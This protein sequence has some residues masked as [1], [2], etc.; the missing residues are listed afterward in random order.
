MFTSPHG[1]TLFYLYCF[2]GTRN[3][4]NSAHAMGPLVI[5]CTVLLNG[6]IA[7]EN[8]LA[9]TPPMGW[10]SWQR[11]RC[12]TNCAQ[13]PDDCISEKLIKRTV[14]RIISDGWKEVG[15]EYVITDDCWPERERDRDTQEIVADRT[16]FPNGIEGLGEYIHGHGLKFGIY[17]DYGTLTCAGYPG[18]MNFLE[19][20]SKSLARWKVDYVKVDGCYSPV[21]A[22]PDGYEKFSRLLNETG[23]PIVYSCSYPAYIPWRSNPRSLDWERLKTNCNL[24]RMFDDIDDSW[25]SVLTIINFMRDTQSTLQPIAGPGHWNDPDMLVIGNFGLSMDQQRVQMGMWCLFAAPLLISADMDH[26]DPGSEEILKNPHLI[27][28]NQDSG[29]HQAKY[30]TTKNGV[31]LW[32][33]QLADQ[34]NTWAIAFMN[35]VSGGGPKAISVA[36]KDMQLESPPLEPIF[37]DL[38]DVFTGEVF[39]SVQLNEMFT[40][41]VNPTG[42]VMFK[43]EVHKPAYIAHILLQYLGL[44]NVSVSII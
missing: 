8:G 17:L 3:Y 26:M 21:E 31:Q 37:F 33:R 20:D 15:Y 23:R 28:I 36:L 9:R 39:G 27:S 29:G 1:Y 42:I 11:F 6:V 5:L 30:I 41:R 24:W 35:P 44:R 38:T 32:T 2:K 14:D 4:K 43:V 7:L 10:M 34:S 25:G 40:V 16:R 12:Q 13:Y 22:M 18:S 19:I